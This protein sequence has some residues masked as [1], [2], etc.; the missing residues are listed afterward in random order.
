M[1]LEELTSASKQ[2]EV[3]VDHIICK[4]F[5]Y[6]LSGDAFSWFSQLLPRSLTCWED[7]K[8]AFLNKFL[9]EA[10]STRQ[11]EFDDMLDKM[12]KGQETELMVGI[13]YSELN[14]ESETMNTQIEKPAIEIQWTDEFVRRE[15]AGITDTSSTSIDGMTST[16]T[17]SRTSTSTYGTTST[18][19]DGTTSSSTDDTTT[20]STDGTTSTSIDSTTSTSTNVTTSMSIDSTISTSTNGTTLTSIDDVEKEITMEDFLEVEEFLEFEDGEKLEDLDSSREVTMEDFL[21][22]E[23]WREDMDQNSEKKL[24]DDHHTSRGDLESGQSP[25]CSRSYAHFTEEWSV[26]LARGSCRGDEG[27]LINITALWAEHIL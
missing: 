16:S 5:P 8:T 18:S 23:E 12:I 2:N 13:V 3:S 15:E 1:K 6:S 9:Y 19:T 24:D 21:E 25:S 22:L 14:E 11:K 27:L 17:D 20:T 26:C 10:T 4:I 7:I